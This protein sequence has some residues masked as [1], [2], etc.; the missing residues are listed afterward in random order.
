MLLRNVYC[1]MCYL[2]QAYCKRGPLSKMESIDKAECMCMYYCKSCF[3][4][5][6]WT[7]RGAHTHT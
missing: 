1:R 3:K 6:N 5:T 7:G 2:L 4:K